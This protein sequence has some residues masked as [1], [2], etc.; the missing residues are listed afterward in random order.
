[1]PGERVKV[2]IEGICLTGELVARSNHNPNEWIVRTYY[3]DM[4]TIVDNIFI[5]SQRREEF[6]MEFFKR[7]TVV[8]VED[9]KAKR[10]GII[11]DSVTRDLDGDGF[12]YIPIVLIGTLKR[13]CPPE[14]LRRVIQCDN[15]EHDNNL[16]Q[17]NA[18]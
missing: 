4:L 13:P 14:I 12:I 6:Y 3:H 11:V 2:I 9:R 8:E 18:H 10:V 15:I 5:I 1:M 16:G 7:G 17:T